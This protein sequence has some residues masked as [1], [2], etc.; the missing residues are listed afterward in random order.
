MCLFICIG[1]PCVCSSPNHLF[2]KTI[3]KL[4][5]ASEHNLKVTKEMISLKKF[6]LITCC[7]SFFFCSISVGYVL[8]CKINVE[9]K[10][11]YLKVLQ[12]YFMCRTLKCGQAD[13]AVF[14]SLT[15]PSFYKCQ[16]YGQNNS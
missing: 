1:Y 7:C 8:T 14:F 15:E 9:Y 6:N 5:K 4:G 12:L 3:A 10:R 11:H 13:S 2:S 16:S